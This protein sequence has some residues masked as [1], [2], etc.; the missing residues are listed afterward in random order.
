MKLLA[1]TLFFFILLSCSLFSQEYTVNTVPNPKSHPTDKFVSNPDG[2]ISTETEDIINDLA[3]S[4][5]KHNGV[6]IAIVL[7]NSVGDIYIKDFAVELFNTWGIGKAGIDN[8]LLILFV[9]NQRAVTFETGYGIESIL[10]DITCKRIQMEHMVPYFK[11]GDY[12]TGIINGMLAVVDVLEK[13]TYKKPSLKKS[14]AE[15][16]YILVGLFKWSII[17]FVLVSIILCFWK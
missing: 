16:H 5:E 10:P 1:L 15:R 12:E 8:G 17:I 4:L 9:N 6:E 11:E 13:E 3:Y 2:I 14:F 7:L